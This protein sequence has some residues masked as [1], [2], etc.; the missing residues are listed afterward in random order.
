MAHLEFLTR[1]FNIASTVSNKIGNLFG[2]AALSLENGGH[3][4]I[5]LG[6]Y[7]YTEMGAPSNGDVISQIVAMAKAMG[8]EPATPQETKEMLHMN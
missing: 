7:P 8:R 4:A 1:Q 6:D 2:P 5:G 3:V